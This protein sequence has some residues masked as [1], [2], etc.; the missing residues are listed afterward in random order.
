MKKPITIC[1][2][3][4][5]LIGG[6]L[7]CFYYLSTHDLFKPKETVTLTNSN[8]VVATPSTTAE[9]V[10]DMSEFSEEVDEVQKDLEAIGDIDAEV[11][12]GNVSLSFPKDFVGEITQAQVDESV[13]KDDGFISGKVNPDGSVTYVMTKE[14]YIELMKGIQEGI[15][16]S[17]Q[18][19]LNNPDYPH[20][21]SIS[22]DDH[23]SEYTITCSSEDLTLGE[24]I[25]ALQLY[26]YSGAYYQ[27]L[28]NPPDSVSLKYVNS[29]T[30]KVFYESNSKDLAKQN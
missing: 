1:V 6:C 10:S 4:V 7:A 13:A 2:I 29:Q 19:T 20:I 30:G 26:I 18:E 15:E 24:S 14:K 9:T 11:V 25:L 23:Y 5:L 12:D 22:H 21:I 3:C 16:K 8:E 27:F 17:I 28:V